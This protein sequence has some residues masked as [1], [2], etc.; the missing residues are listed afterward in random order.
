MNQMTE[1]ENT[2]TETEVASTPAPHPGG[3]PSTRQSRK[4]R[5]AAKAKPAK[6]AKAKRK[7]SAA[8]ARKANGGKPM[9]ALKAA[10]K[11]YKVDKSTKT[12]GGNPT[13][14][15]GDATAKALAGKD[16][17]AVYEK[18]AKVKGVSA[19]TLKAKYRHLN[20]GAQ[21]MT[22]GNIIRAAS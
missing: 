9:N 4:S 6:K 7:P 20:P 12:A 14:H 22:L 13:I 15:C 17:N 16:L 3:H 11:Q 18:A 19:G 21:R 2:A 5:K 10:R 8:R 1:G